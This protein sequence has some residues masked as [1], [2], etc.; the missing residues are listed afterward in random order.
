M[1]VFK[2]GLNFED[3]LIKGKIKGDDKKINHLNFLFVIEVVENK[4][5]VNQKEDLIVF[6]SVA[7]IINVKKVV[8]IF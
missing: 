4:K 2:D 8:I 6:K 1:F 3:V 5:I 7:V